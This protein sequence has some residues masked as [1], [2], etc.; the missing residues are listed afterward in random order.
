MIVYQKIKQPSKQAGSLILG[1]SP[2]IIDKNTF[3]HALKTVA[4]LNL[5]LAKKELPYFC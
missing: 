4:H 2:F 3:L 5:Q 1:M